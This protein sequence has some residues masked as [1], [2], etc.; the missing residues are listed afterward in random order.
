M[1]V[2]NPRK[3]MAISAADAGRARRLSSGNIF[4]FH[5]W[6][7]V[8][9]FGFALVYVAGANAQTPPVT[10]TPPAGQAQPPAQSIQPGQLAQSAPPPQTTPPPQSTPPPQT[11][12]PA[13]TP[14]AAVQTPPA[15]STPA[16][17]P[18]PA[19][20]S[21]ESPGKVWGNYLMHQSVEIGY[22][23]SMIGGNQNNYDTFENLQSGLR[24]LD[25]SVD[26]HSI[27]HQGI[28]FD[29]L[30][31]SNFGYGGDPN[32]VSRL[33]IDKNKWYDFRGMFR[34]DLNFWNYDLLANPLNPASSNP[35]IAVTSSPQA[36]NLSRHMQ[37]Y[38][39]TLL[40][41]SRLRFRLGYS[42]NTNSGLAAGSVEGGTEPLLSQTLLY[43]TSS[44]RFGAD[45]RGIPKTTLSFD[46]LLTYSKIDERETDNNLTYQTSTGLPVDLGLLFNTVGA[47]PC[48]VPFSNT[49]TTPFTVTPTC[50]AYLSYGEVQNPRS[51]FPTEQFRFQSAYFKNFA[52]T[53]SL[54]YSSG[55][56]VISDY[57]ELINGY[58]SR[59]VTRG[60]TTAGP[61]EAKRISVNADWSGD[62]RISEKWSIADDFSFENWRSPTMWNSAETNVFGTPP[63]APGQ[64]GLLLPQSTVTPANFATVCPAAPYNSALCP[65]HV[66]GSGADVTRQFVQQFLG[67]DIK[68]NLIELRYDV[69]RKVSAHLGYMYMSRNIAD[70]SATFNDGEIYFPG[71]A[72]GT[73]ANDFLAARGDCALV[74]GA[75]PAGCVK[76]AN[77]SVQLGTPAN[78]TPV[79]G[80]DTA[81]NITQIHESAAVFGIAAM[82][83]DTLRLNA[84]LMFG[85]NDNTFTRISPRQLQSYK[86]HASYQ[87][88]PWAR[89]EG[90]VDIH[91]NRDNVSM[92]NNLEHGRTYSFMTTLSPGANLWV[93]FGYHFMDVFTQTEI[94]FADTGSTVFTTACPIPLSTGPLG[95]LSFYSSKDHYAYADVMWKPVK[96]VTAMFGYNGSIVRGNTTFLNPLQPTGTLDFN[97][98]K[99]FVSLAIDI[100]KDLTYKT[101][102]NYF[103]YNDRGIANP[104]GL[105]PIP[106]Q[107]FN[108]SNITFSLKYRY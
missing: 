28:V 101:A 15:A 2:S 42:R 59:T 13:Q 11:I 93:D 108:G 44:Y 53:G 99:P 66:S 41:Q 46:E 76:N 65:Q 5:G 69:S 94:C 105:A 80:N 34:R 22:R 56:N 50:N 45:Y 49:T 3:K 30:T 73:V 33:H 23:D 60:S 103:G 20:A 16:A 74:A 87:P 29:S 90:A 82:P 79:I 107:D 43:R 40:P 57:N 48:A 70:F 102:W 89:L 104:I 92:V 75:L 9:V 10:Q 21:E 85:Y 4:I 38:D 7:R 35:A 54:G 18:A 84:E 78:P 39:L 88:K 32:N 6:A 26:M 55:N 62:Y 64:A 68:K 83:I 14:P 63:A 8:A 61:A 77:G 95:T 51:S 96:R 1:T 17:A 58:T 91:E 67:Q 106:A 19:P 37:D 36:L 72:T 86:I 97:Y 52:M 24:L 27:N 31:F 71:G 81:R 12:P 98:L 100:R 47:V 25:F